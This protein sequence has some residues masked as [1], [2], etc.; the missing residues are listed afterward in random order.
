MIFQT[1]TLVFATE[2]I[3]TRHYPAQGN[4]VFL[5]HGA[6]NA[7]QAT[8]YKIALFLQQKQFNTISFDYS[9]HGESSNEKPS[10]ILTKTEQARAVMQYYSQNHHKIHLFAW[11]MSGQ[12][13]VNLLENN[14]HIV[15]L[16]LFAPALYAEDVMKVEFGAAFTQAIREYGNWQRSN[17]TRILPHFSGCLNLVRPENDAIIPPEVSQ[18]YREYAPPH[19]QEI[20]LPHAPHTLGAWFDEDVRRFENVFRQ[21]RFFQ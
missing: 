21:I 5:L 16:T 8:L 11:S 20:I 15:S 7:N 6:G 14:P 3:A 2:K 1:H 10:S 12:I 13:A 18:I 17:A 9:G 4:T 19:F